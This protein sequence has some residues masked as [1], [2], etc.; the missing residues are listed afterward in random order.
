M[1][2]RRER[3]APLLM[4]AFSFVFLIGLWQLLVSVGMLNPFLTSSPARVVSALWAQASSGTLSRNIAATMLE[5]A[6]TFGMATV[7][8]VGVGT[9][10][11]WYEPVADG[12]S[13]FIA[14]GYS[15]PF[16]S[17]Y[18]VFVVIFGFGRTTVIAIGFCIGVFPI[19]VN[20]ARGVG[21]VDPKLVQV[22]RSFGANDLKLFRKVALPAALQPVMAGLRL[23]LGACLLGVIVGELFGG[24][25]GIGYS[26]S[27][28][29][30]LLQTDNMMAAVVVV[31][32]CGVVLS[33][34]LTLVERRLQGW[35]A[36]GR[37]M[38][39]RGTSA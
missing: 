6:I 20:T 30:G 23:G 22:A 37:K 33:S 21:S 24:S 34:G 10:V 5:L 38:N 3:V 16:V 8:G 2:T 18:P 13:P 1:S 29:G 27:Y 15:A 12:L 11:G 36:G 32:I 9:L 35:V 17:L 25:V 26:V 28:Y 14:I 31:G 39:R 19:L 4:G 7:V